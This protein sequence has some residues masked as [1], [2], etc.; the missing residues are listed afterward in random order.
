MQIADQERLD[1]AFSGLGPERQF[2]DALALGKIQLQRC[3][4]CEKLIYYPRVA[5]PA[6]GAVEFQWEQLSGRGSI[7]AHT[8]FHRRGEDP[9]CLALVD[10][11]EGARI[12]TRIAT[13]APDTIGI[14]EAVEASIEEHP[15]GLYLKFT[16]A[17]PRA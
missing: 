9:L 16:P 7:Y 2:R 17:A 6:C 3:Q 1:R 4:S 12:Y 11:E 10:L 14:G 5:C 8:T 15:L 13:D